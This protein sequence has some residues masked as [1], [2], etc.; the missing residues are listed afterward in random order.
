M[1]TPIEIEEKEFKTSLFG[2]KKVEVDEFL[3]VIK[4][5]YEGLLKENSVLKE[6]IE[7]MQNQISKYE[8]I[9]ETLKSTLVT[10]QRTAEDICVSANQ[11]AKL[12]VEDANM[13][14]RH[15]IE[16]ANDRVVDIRKER[17]TILKEFKIFRSKFKSLLNDEIKN[18][19]EIFG[20][21]DEE[22]GNIF[23]GTAMY[24]YTDSQFA[25]AFPRYNFNK[26]YYKKEDTDFAEDFQLEGASDFERE[27]DEL[28]FGS[29]FEENKFEEINFATKDAVNLEKTDE[30]SEF[31]VAMTI[32]P[33][34]RYDSD[35]IVDDCDENENFEVDFDDDFEEN[36]IKNIV[37][38]SEYKEE[39]SS[40]YF[41]EDRIK[42]SVNFF[43][44]KEAI[45]PN[46]EATKEFT[47]EFAELRFLK[48]LGKKDTSFDIEISDDT[49]NQ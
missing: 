20:D 29:A 25:A 43:N 17:D 11:K 49:N 34:L 47:D 38:H 37:S 44:K 2:F 18:I 10:A 39:D 24:T 26:E 15:V 42:D 35:E 8:N 36:E 33:D 23:E 3:D 22:I 1:L 13:K 19:D 31:E 14:S 6:K 12:I 7:L 41:I 40:N 28:E 45:N 32:D 46:E 21:V 4:I 48:S 5:N 27:N 9:E 16:Q 30:N